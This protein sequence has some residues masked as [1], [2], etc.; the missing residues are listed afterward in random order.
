MPE[1]LIYL[2]SIKYVQIEVLYH[3]KRVDRDRV[4]SIATGW[5]VRGWNPGKSEVFRTRPDRPWGPT[6]LL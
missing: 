3:R 6:S 5:T 4:V 1:E 2:H